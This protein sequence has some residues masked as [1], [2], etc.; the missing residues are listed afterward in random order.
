L[1]LGCDAAHLV[2]V[3]KPRLEVL[4]TGLPGAN[5]SDMMQEDPALLFE[6]LES[7]KPQAA[8]ADFTRS[9]HQPPGSCLSWLVVQGQLLDPT[10]S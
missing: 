2:E 5:I 1:L 8:I 6:K 4:S 7:G 9:L 10:C 3:V